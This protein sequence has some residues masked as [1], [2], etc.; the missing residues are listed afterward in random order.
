MLQLTGGGVV[1]LSRARCCRPCLPAELP[2]SPRQLDADPQGVAIVSIGCHRSTGQGS[3]SLK[4]EPQGSSFV[5]GFT[6][7]IRVSNAASYYY[8]V[9]A[10]ECCTPSVLLSTGDAWELERC[11]C[12]FSTDINCGEQATNRLLQGFERWRIT[13]L[14]LVPIGPAQCCK[15]CLSKTIHPLDSCADLNFCSG[16]GVCNLGSCDCF[17]GFGGSDCGNVLGGSGGQLPQ[18]ATSLIII[19]SCVLVTTLVL[20]AGRIVHYVADRHAE[21]EEEEGLGEPLIL[22]IDQDDQGSVGSEDTSRYDSDDDLPPTEQ[23]AV[24]GGVLIPEGHREDSD[25][26]E[27]Q[28]F[29]VPVA[30]GIQLETRRRTRST[31]ADNHAATGDVGATDSEDEV[32]TAEDLQRIE[33]A[34]ASIDQR[35]QQTTTAQTASEVEEPYLNGG[36]PSLEEL[37]AEDGAHDGAKDGAVDDDVDDAKK[38]VAFELGGDDPTAVLLRGAECNVCMNRPVQ[39]VVI[40]CGHATLCRRCSRRLVRCPVCRKEILRR[41]RMYLGG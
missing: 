11:D 8:P 32:D 6:E 2:D 21:E 24:G 37:H 20:A 25:G 29:V 17:D 4:C 31:P 7:A 34:A 22:R 39:V 41:Q 19:G 35:M 26:G 15:T 5:T 33:A 16:R 36:N 38:D 10:V 18:W 30:N 28:S 23:E 14:G 27:V 12:M 3:G 9:G 40:P 1:P 13:A